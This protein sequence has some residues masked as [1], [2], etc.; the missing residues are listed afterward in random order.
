MGSV[1]ERLR[2]DGSHRPHGDRLICWGLSLEV[3]IIR[4]PSASLSNKNEKVKQ[5]IRKK[6]HKPTSLRWCRSLM[7]V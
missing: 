3:E 5:Y 6:T 4:N 1:E 2:A 7:Y